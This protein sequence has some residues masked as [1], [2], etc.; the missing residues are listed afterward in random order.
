MCIIG[1]ASTK[2][3][4]AHG[5]PIIS[6]SLSPSLAVA[7]TPSRSRMAF[8]ADIAGTRLI[9]SAIVSTPGMFIS[10]VTYVLRSE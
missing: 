1:C 10:V 3:P 2:S 4:T 6:A 8:L 5:M 9:A 7:F